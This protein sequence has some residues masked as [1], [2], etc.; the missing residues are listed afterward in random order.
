MQRTKI[1]AMLAVTL[2]LGITI[3]GLAY[4]QLTT[5]PTTT[6]TPYEPFQ[7]R[8]NYWGWLRGCLRTYNEQTPYQQMPPYQPPQNEVG[9]QA[10]IPPHTIQPPTYIQPQIPNQGNYQYRYG[11]GC[12][13]W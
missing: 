7:L 11:H 13:G 8:S 1:L 10:P 12:W 5:P 9:P 6:T 3:T 4:A 2:A